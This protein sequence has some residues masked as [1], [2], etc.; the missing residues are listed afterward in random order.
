[1]SFLHRE[2]TGDER[3]LEIGEF[4]TLT[5]TTHVELKWVIVDDRVGHLQLRV[6]VFTHLTVCRRS[7]GARLQ[8]VLLNRIC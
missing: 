2:P 6:L 3:R 1:M 8:H 7:E 4:H 5:L